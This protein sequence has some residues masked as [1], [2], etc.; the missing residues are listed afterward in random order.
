MRGPTELA[1]H[2]RPSR[3][4][5]SAANRLPQGLPSRQQV[6]DFLA[7]AQEEVGKRE[8]AKAFGL[9]GHE[10]IQLKALLKDMASSG[11]TFHARAGAKT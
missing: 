9:K 6:L 8:I 1:H 3:K 7:N 5:L 2:D 4:T 10:K 11:R